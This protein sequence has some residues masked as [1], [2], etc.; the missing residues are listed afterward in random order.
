[1]KRTVN[2][3]GL[4]VVGLIMVFSPFAG[5][6]EESDVTPVAP[7]TIAMTITAGAPPP[8]ASQSVVVN[9]SD[10]LP[11]ITDAPAAI[12]TVLAGPA[13]GTRFGDIQVEAV[14]EDGLLV[15]V[16]TLA[17]PK[18]RRSRSINGQ[19]IPFYEAAAI[20][21]QSADIDVL[22]GATVTWQAY[23]ESLQ[24]ALDAAGL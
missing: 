11:E 6:I 24:G 3:V 1:M 9:E 22:S 5:L 16:V 7:E 21:D 15:D 4:L 20:E 23:T 10:P 8:N 17:E 2:Q 19:A 13:V 18:D 12:N 14:I